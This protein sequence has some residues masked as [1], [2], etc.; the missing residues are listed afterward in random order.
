MVSRSRFLTWYYR[1]KEARKRSLAKSA[2]FVRFR[3]TREGIHLLFVVLFI[4]VGAVLRDINLLILIAA[5]MIGL[6]L[7][8]WRFNVGT[9]TGLTTARKLP[10]RVSQGKPVSCQLTVTNPK[11]WLG[12]WLILA[13]DAVEQLAPVASPVPSKGATLID[14]IPPRMSSTA[15]FDLVF[16]NRGRFR[17]GPSM[18]STRFPLNLGRGWRT[19]ENSQEILVHPRLGELTQAART[20]LFTDREGQAKSSV[21]AGVHETEFFGLRPWVNGDSRRWIHWR[22]TA[23]MGELSV[24]QFERL[25]QQQVCVLL[26]LYCE[27]GKQSQE[28]EIACEKAISFVATLA[29]RTV[30]V[31]GNKLNVAIAA[32]RT[33]TLTSIQSPVLVQNLLDELAVVA[34]SPTPDRRSALSK[35]TLALLQNPNLIVVSTRAATTEELQS[36]FSQLLGPK[37]SSRIKCQWINV[38]N[39]ELEPYFSWTYDE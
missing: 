9:I 5:A 36:D 6:L 21:H 7:L 17:V 13:E 39:G 20:L 23:K 10:E 3:L 11:R 29:H 30:R 35:M 38:A 24:R 25:Q 31:A 2:E 33:V 15:S 4:F 37:S 18:L 27:K 28:N 14:E 26:D 1:Y 22:T 12:A 32:E 16:L 8:Q 19:L 34:P